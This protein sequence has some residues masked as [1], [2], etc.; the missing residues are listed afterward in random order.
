MA[1]VSEGSSTPSTDSAPERDSGRHRP[2]QVYSGI[3]SVPVWV[4]AKY[5]AKCVKNEIHN[6]L[7]VLKLEKSERSWSHRSA[8]FREG[9]IK[10]FQALFDE[11]TYLDDFNEFDTVRYLAPFLNVIQSEDA[12]GPLTAVAL[13]SV[14][15]FVSFGLIPT[16]KMGPKAINTLVAGVINC[17]FGAEGT[18]DDEVVLL[19]MITVLVDA[20]RCPTGAQLTDA[21]V[22]QMVRKIHQV[23]KQPMGLSHLLRSSAEQQLTLIV[24]T[25]FNQRGGGSSSGNGYSVSA[26]YCLLRYMA[27]LMTAG[28]PGSINGTEGQ[29][30]SS[31]NIPLSNSSSSGRSRTPQR[32]TPPQQYR[33][34]RAPSP[35]PYGSSDPEAEMRDL[36]DEGGRLSL[37]GPFKASDSSE[38]SKAMEETRSLGLSLLNVALETGG[39]DMCNHE[40]LISVIQ[41]D[42]CKALLMNSTANESLRVLSATLRA[43]F[44]LFQH[45]KRHLKVQLEIFFT[46]IHLK[47]V[48]AAGSRSMEQ[49][50]LALESL[51]EFCREPELMVELYENYDC[52]VHCTNLFERLV[53]LLMSVATDTQS[54]TD[55]DKGVGEASSPAVQNER[56][57]NL[58]TM[59]LN[60]LLAIV[61][62]IAVRTEQASKELSTQGNLPLLT[63]TDTQPLDVDDTVQQGAKLELRKEQKRR[64]ALAAQAFNSS[65]SKCVPT[66]QSLG[67]LSDP[68]TAKAFAHFCRHT[69]GLDMK[70]LGEFLAKRQDFNGEIRKEFMH[71]FKFA[72]MPVVEALRLMLA[73]FRLP[74]E[75]QEIERIVES[76]SL[77]YFGAQQRAASEEGPD[78]RLVYRECE[79]DAD[80]NPTDPVIMHSSDTVFILSYSLIML[81]TDL[82]N[83]MVKNKMS[84]DEFKRNNRGIDA[85]RDLD[86]DFLTD[87][88]NSIYDEE[89]RLFDSVPGAEKVVDQREWDNLM[90]KSYEVGEFSLATGGSWSLAHDKAMFKVVWNDGDI[91]DSLSRSFATADAFQVSLAGWID[92]ARAAALLRHADAF[93]KIVCRLG[94]FFSPPLTVRFQLAAQ[95]L[96]MWL[97]EYGFLLQ[98]NGWR[99]M[100]GWLAGLWALGLLPDSLSELEDFVDSH[101]KPLV[102]IAPRAFQPPGM[103]PLLR[104]SRT[105]SQ[106][107]DVANNSGFL[108][109]LSSYFGG[110]SDS[111]SEDD[112]DNEPLSPTAS[113]KKAES[114][115]SQ[116]LPLEAVLSAP[117]SATPE[118]VDNVEQ[119]L[120]KQLVMDPVRLADCFSADRIR[121]LGM[122]SLKA[123]VTVLCK[124]ASWVPEQDPPGDSWKPWSQWRRVGDPVM[125]LEILTMVTTSVY[126]SSTE[127]NLCREVAAPHLLSLLQYAHELPEKALENPAFLERV[128]VNAMRISIRL[129]E[130]DDGLPSVR[131]LLLSLASLPKNVFARVAER[132]AS[133]LLLLVRQRQ[134]DEKTLSAIL[135]LLQAIAECPS[136][137]AVSFNF[138]MQCV[139][140]LA[141]SGLSPA[142]SLLYISL[143]RVLCAFSICQ[144]D[145]SLA[146]KSLDVL[147][148][149]LPAVISQAHGE[150]EEW[151]PL[152]IPTVTSVA[153]IIVRTQH[154]PLIGRAENTL[155]VLLLEGPQSQ[156]PSQYWVK[157]VSDIFIPLLQRYHSPTLSKVALRVVLYHL[158]KSQGLWG[159]PIP[160]LVEAVCK[161]PDAD[162]DEGLIQGVRN[163][164]MVTATDPDLRDTDTAHQLLDTVIRLLPVAA[165][166]LEAILNWDQEE[167]KEKK[168]DSR[169]SG[170]G[171]PVENEPT[172]SN[173]VRQIDDVS[174]KGST[175]EGG[176]SGQIPAE[177]HPQ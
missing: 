142:S 2:P 110:I 44:N 91:L 139:S 12:S 48:P 5:P 67:L 70:I 150:L 171:D 83:P 66:L 76:F 122:P 56:K 33:H 173:N 8:I 98:S 79:M 26:R 63:R 40:A 10:Q 102:S 86:S 4:G 119:H 130:V 118:G 115:L 27:F 134:P 105:H 117:H 36:F 19:K 101:G 125:N 159:H 58:S 71:S 90:R 37:G 99:A 11:L 169:S 108:A 65:P 94:D 147:S 148:A 35:E 50:E 15:K 145:E 52:D 57:K 28:F 168:T 154:E 166:G 72:G 32:G 87:I 81:N 104:S 131:S 78:A 85:G 156:I 45:F 149:L 41:N 68:V 38:T 120:K 74:G 160:S 112:D 109:V 100:M 146:G 93:N 116:I 1:A 157:L 84:L 107:G 54:A 129:I 23:A 82:H 24:L 138:A 69:P 137:S 123:L 51:L 21:C 64:L 77:A 124:E 128:A 47:M 167:D 143:T 165:E 39:A 172:Q 53:K 14:N 88:Y 121:V 135:A 162:R 132:A 158:S 18:P 92:L 25:V 177:Q 133:G 113:L 95:T 161:C 152:W 136:T 9:A 17:R 20:L 60:G 75:A 30:G 114:N 43:V 46:S 140:H 7:T 62:G 16:D 174:P 175:K 151:L 22:W 144:L 89:I 49:R 103:A 80:G 97:R 73:T 127:P 111:D 153:T 163:L 31:A 141:E 59:A 164:L 170:N 13:D 106:S 3:G 29:R 96:G 34:L 155:R 6:I 42:I 176:D 55:E 61:R 126:V